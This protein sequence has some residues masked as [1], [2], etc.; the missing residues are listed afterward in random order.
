[1]G[2]SLY[3]AN[4]ELTGYRD[5]ACGLA[6]IKYR[7]FRY[8]GGVIYAAID[9]AYE[10]SN[11]TA[12]SIGTKQSGEYYVIGKVYEE[13]IY[14][15]YGVISK[16]LQDNYVMKCFYEN[17]ADKGLGAKS[18]KRLVLLKSFLMLTR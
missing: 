12:V 9:P 17:N 11:R 16:L 14:E 5:E 10:G 8:E 6:E 3:Y 7:E 15:L 13:P 2:K 4:Y 18:F 1:M